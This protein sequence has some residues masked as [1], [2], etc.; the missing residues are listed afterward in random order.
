MSWH[1]AR[2]NFITRDGYGRISLGMSQAEVRDAL[3]APVVG[4]SGQKWFVNLLKRLARSAGLVRE[5]VGGRA[6]RRGGHF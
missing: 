1:A 5:K 2:R 4:G 6:V 3:G